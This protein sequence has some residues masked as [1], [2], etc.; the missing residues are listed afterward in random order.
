MRPT[1]DFNA[2]REDKLTFDELIEGIT[3]N[4]LRDLTNEMIDTVNGLISDCVDADVTFKPLDPE[5]D[6]PYAST[7]EEVQMAWTLGHVIVHIT[8]SAEEAASLAAELARGVRYHGRSRYEIPWEEAG[9][10]GDCR[11]RLEESRRMRLASLDVWPDE[12]HSENEYEAWSGGPKVNAIGRFVLGLM[13][14]ESHLE[15]IQDIV[16]Q[17]RAARGESRD[18]S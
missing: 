13:H 2:V 15:Q 16:K 6:D 9:T 4:D 18:A 14:D 17:A 3:P 12:P 7:P 5:A 10:I 1:L 8:A 11:Q